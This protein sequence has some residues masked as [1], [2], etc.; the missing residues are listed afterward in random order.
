M[1]KMNPNFDLFPTS[2]NYGGQF[3]SQVLQSLQRIENQLMSHTPTWVPHNDF[4]SNHLMEEIRSRIGGSNSEES[5]MSMLNR[6]HHH[7]SVL[8]SSDVLNQARAPTNLR[9]SIN[10]TLMQTSNSLITTIRNDIQNVLGRYTDV[11][12]ALSQLRNSVDEAR[13]C[14]DRNHRSELDLVTSR[15]Q[16]LYNTTAQLV[17][18]SNDNTTM[19]NELRDAINRANELL[20]QNMNHRRNDINELIQENLELRQNLQKLVDA[21]NFTREPSRPTA[22]PRNFCKGHP[23]K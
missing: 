11:N 21:L 12:Q 6:I 2:G 22:P 18:Q 15:I 4:S 14:S 17:G 9:E 1:F 20:S 10:D 19:I 3:E 16:E 5:L 23:H 7:M 8:N 13:L